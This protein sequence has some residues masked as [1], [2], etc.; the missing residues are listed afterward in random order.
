MAPKRTFGKSTSGPTATPQSNAPP[1]NGHRYDAAEKIWD[2][3]PMTMSLWFVQTIEDLQDADPKFNRLVESATALTAK[4]QKIAVLS[5]EHAQSDLNGTIAI[6][7]FLTP[8]MLRRSDFASGYT[9]F[10]T[11]IS[12]E[13]LPPASPQPVRAAA[14]AAPTPGDGATSAA[15]REAVHPALSILT[16]AA[17]LASSATPTTPSALVAAIGSEH[18]SNYAI[19]PHVIEEVDLELL[20]EFLGRIG[21]ARIKN[22][23][24]ARC[25]KSGRR[26]IIEFLQ[27][28]NDHPMGTNSATAMQKIID[29]MLTAGCEATV[30]SFLALTEKVRVWNKCQVKAK[31]L[32]ED[33]LAEKFKDLVIRMGEVAENKLQITINNAVMQTMVRKGDVDAAMP[34]IIIDSCCIVLGDL[35][36]K[37]LVSELEGKALLGRDPSRTGDPKNKT[38][39]PKNKNKFDKDKNRP[40]KHCG[41]NHWDNKCPN[42]PEE[43]PK[44][45]PGTEA[46]PKGEAG[47]SALAR[48]SSAFFAGS[49]SRD[50]DLELLSDPEAA[51]AALADS[52]P[53]RSLVARGQKTAEVESDESGEG[54][55]SQICEVVHDQPLDS[56]PNARS[57]NT[58]RALPIE[59]PSSALVADGSGTT[60]G[61]SAASAQLAAPASHTSAPRKGADKLAIIAVSPKLACGGVYCGDWQKDVRHRIAAELA[62]RRSAAPGATWLQASPST[63]V[64]RSTSVYNALAWAVEQGATEVKFHGPRMPAESKVLDPTGKLL[65]DLR[66]VGLGGALPLKPSREESSEVDSE[67]ELDAASAE[68][69]AGETTRDYTKP[70]EGSPPPSPPCDDLESQAPREPKRIGSSVGS[71]TVLLVILLALCRLI[72]TASLAHFI[73]DPGMPRAAGLVGHGRHLVGG[74]AGLG[75]LLLPFLTLTLLALALYLQAKQPKGPPRGVPPRPAF[76]QTVD[77]IY[78]IFTSFSTTSAPTRRRLAATA[79]SPPPVR[80][81]RL[82]RERAPPWLFVLLA[83]IRLSHG[84]A[85]LA[86]YVGV[87]FGAASWPSWQSD[88]TVLACRAGVMARGP[89]RRL[90]QLLWRVS[91]AVFYFHAAAAYGAYCDLLHVPGRAVHLVRLLLTALVVAFNVCHA[92]LRFNW[93]LATFN[94]T[95]LVIMYVLGSLVPRWGGVELSRS[96]SA[97]SSTTTDTPTGPSEVPTETVVPSKADYA[98]AGYAAP[99]PTRSWSAFKSA[100]A[101]VRHG[102]ALLNRKMPRGKS[103]ARAKA[104]AL[105]AR[106][107]GALEVVIDS[108]CS[109]HVHPNLPDLIN[110][111]RCNDTITGVDNEEHRCVAI[112]DLPIIAK[113][114]RGRL[115][116][117]LLRNVRCVPQFTETPL[118][119][120]GTHFSASGY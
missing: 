81:L 74:L 90:A 31:I 48:A 87:V 37:Q 1:G 3:D 110:Q 104:A 63:F 100:D 47:T 77:I 116:R 23:Y 9:P 67:P 15:E 120:R 58:A 83:L 111:R 26:F 33:Q 20:Q 79:P 41:G 64:R 97:S 57:S 102:R 35:E 85:G 52:A 19:A 65:C 39:D 34:K 95:R 99:P 73:K 101:S 53:A 12:S 117:F 69:L 16:E 107:R 54:Q 56:L 94:L 30:A 105:A 46:K 49:G 118:V 50:L 51:L 14:Q 42:K 29:G 82:I 96:S 32:P 92:V 40:C 66:D 113:D 21:P 2:G 18:A 108:G 71:F 10:G 119:I 72:A 27:D 88:V 7:T 25:S 62:A 114:R 55:D 106:A 60:A 8:C 86:E 68:A 80:T 93:V 28:I 13:E 36:G 59:L 45:T 70:L 115:R 44:N 4:G 98:R 17:R 75:A 84:G 24:R 112:G 6:G 38:G 89:L 76:G 43:D 78:P 22:D 109:W 5:A 91:G 11:A 61:V 103:K